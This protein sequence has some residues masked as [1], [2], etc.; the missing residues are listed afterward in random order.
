MEVVFF[1]KNF[2]FLLKKTTSIRR[3]LSHKVQ[4]VDADNQNHQQS[5]ANGDGFFDKS[6][7]YALACDDFPQQKD[8]ITTVQSRYW[9]Q[10]HKA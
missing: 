3:P 8:D 10:I 5:E 7:A 9:E 1:D 4:Q 2:Q 6:V